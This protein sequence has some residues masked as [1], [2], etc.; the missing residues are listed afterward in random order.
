MSLV[1]CCYNNQQVNNSQILFPVMEVQIYRNLFRITKVCDKMLPPFYGPQSIWQKRE[2][3]GWFDVQLW[4]DG[5]KQ[6]WSIHWRHIQWAS[7]FDYCE[8]VYCWLYCRTV[9]PILSFTTPNKNTLPPFIL[10]AQWTRL[11]YKKAL[12]NWNYALNHCVWFS[13]KKIAFN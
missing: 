11:I 1:G 4:S 10:T 3:A 7:L 5:Y 8:L 9:S 12:Q 6:V 2:E 13:L